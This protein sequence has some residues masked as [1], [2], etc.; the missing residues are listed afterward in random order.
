MFLRPIFVSL[1]GDVFGNW[2]EIFLV[3]R[4]DPFRNTS[5]VSIDTTMARICNGRFFF[6][7]GQ[8][9]FS[10]VHQLVEDLE[11]YRALYEDIV[12]KIYR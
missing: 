4:T 6:C 7:V 1:I 3:G 11:Q 5:V 8:A 10:A 9:W 12:R 2:L